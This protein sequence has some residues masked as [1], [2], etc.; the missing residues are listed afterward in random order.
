MRWACTAAAML[1][2][3]AALNRRNRTVMSLDMWRQDD[4]TWTAQQWSQCID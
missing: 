3:L 4:G 2:L 1:P